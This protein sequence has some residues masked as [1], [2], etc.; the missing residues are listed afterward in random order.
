VEETDT[1]S[2]CIQTNTGWPIK[3]TFSKINGKNELLHI[4][5]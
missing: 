1:L 3:I 2:K 5:V 4:F